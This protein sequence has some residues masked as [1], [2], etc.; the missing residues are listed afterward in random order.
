M[1]IAVIAR[2]PSK[3]AYETINE[4]LSGSNRPSESPEG[5]IIHTA[6]EGP[7]GFCVVDV[8]DSREAFETFMNDQ[9][10]PAMQET[11]MEMQ[12]AQPE[13][14]ELVTVLVNERARV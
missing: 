13:I 12:G 5:N 7:N 8:W 2:I 10:M 14:I 4:K 11:G 9:I 3:E 6:G 1:A